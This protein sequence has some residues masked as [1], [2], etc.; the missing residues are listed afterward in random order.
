MYSYFFVIKSRFLL[1]YR[2]DDAWIIATMIGETSEWLKAAN[3]AIN[4]FN[5]D[6]G[7]YY[8]LE[9]FGRITPKII[10]LF[11]TAIRVYRHL[12][13]ISMAWSL[14]EIRDVEDLQLLSGHIYM[15][16]GNLQKAQVRGLF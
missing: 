5:L 3:A 6:F 4:E 16:M 11:F 10:K 9:D 15:I 2:Y 7:T 13:D 1:L 12:G 8:N 14:E